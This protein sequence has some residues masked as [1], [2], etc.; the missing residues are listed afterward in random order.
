MLSFLLYLVLC[1]RFL[2]RSE[3][4][5]LFLF[6]TSLLLFNPFIIEYFSLARGYGLS[7]G[8]M[9]SSLYFLFKGNLLIQRHQSIIKDFA[10]SMFFASMAL[11]SSLSAIN[12][13]IAVLLIFAFQYLWLTITGSV[14]TL[15]DH[16]VF[17]GIILLSCIPLVFAVR[18]LFW[19]RIS[20]QLYFG[21]ESFDYTIFS[22]IMNSLNHKEYHPIF[23][24]IKYFVYLIFPLG[25][26]FIIL[27]KL[28]YGPFFKITLLL[29]LIT[30]GL[31]IE[32]LLFGVKYPVERAAIY[33]VPLSA[34][35]L[36][37]F[38][39]NLI[40]YIPARS[41]IIFSVLLC[42]LIALPLFGVFLSTSNF[43]YTTTWRYDAHTKDM[44]QDI[45]GLTSKMKDNKDKFSIGNHWLFEPAIN[46]YIRSR[47]LNFF[48][49]TRDSVNTNADFLYEFTADQNQP[50]YKELSVYKDIGTGLYQ[51]TKTNK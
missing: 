23:D 30:S 29:I 27:K 35:F 18:R 39:E 2:K 43:T 12:F 37:F 49:A 32:H 33:F 51:K 45:E 16:S 44:M 47:N 19:L 4:L 5:W 9:M 36:Y 7:L 42:S 41:T 13:F 31:V 25:I 40:Q 8:F 1:Y 50:S 17:S 34:L 46:Y 26:L 10:V 22:L 14:H 11:L 28:F 3:N 6:G 38:V 21:S 20:N 24:V 15:K 48:P